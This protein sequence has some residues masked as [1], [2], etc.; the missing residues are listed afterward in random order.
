MDRDEDIPFF[1]FS[2]NVFATCDTHSRLPVKETDV[3]YYPGNSNK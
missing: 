3:S 2:N 1:I